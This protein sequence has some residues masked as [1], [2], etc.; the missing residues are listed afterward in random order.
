MIVICHTCSRF[1]DGY[2]CQALKQHAPQGMTQC[3]QYEHDQ[4]KTQGDKPKTQS[5]HG[6]KP[7]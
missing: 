4:T 3:P 2:Y 1:E 7:Q 5:K 6:V